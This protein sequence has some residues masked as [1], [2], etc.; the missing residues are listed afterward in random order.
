MGISIDI[1]SPKLL[2]NIFRNFLGIKTPRFK[3]GDTVSFKTYGYSSKRKTV[4][5]IILDVKEQNLN[6]Y[7][8]TN[9]ISNPTKIFKYSIKLKDNSI[10][11]AFNE[12]ELTVCKL[13]LLEKIKH[14]IDRRSR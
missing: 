13:I 6:M 8:P 3:T 10:K 4:K 5:G 11:S 1:L 9:H 7:N 2:L 12:D 14:G